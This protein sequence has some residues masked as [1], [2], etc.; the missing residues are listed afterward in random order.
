MSKMKTTVDI[1]QDMSDLYEALKAGTI[2]VKIAS[3][4]ANISGKFLKAEQIELARSVF[5]R[6][7][8]RR[9]GNDGE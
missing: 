1:K 9:S 5:E 4:L 2:D 8:S 7:I 6:G 3:E